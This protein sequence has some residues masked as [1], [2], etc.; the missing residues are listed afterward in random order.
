[1][2][3]TASATLRRMLVIVVSLLIVKVTIA[4]MSGYSNYFPPNF[5]SDFLLGRDDYFFGAYQWVFYPHIVG[6]PVAIFLGLMLVSDRFRQRFPRWHRRL[7]RV[8]VFNV[9]FVVAPSGLGMA[10]ATSTG[11]IAGVGFGGLAVL[12]A[13]CS[14]LGWGAA[15]RRQ[16]AVHR[17]WMWRTFLLLCSAVVLRLLAG[18][19]TVLDIRSPWF[20]PLASW[21]NWLLPLLAFELSRWKRRVQSRSLVPPTSAQPTP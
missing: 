15:V 9:L 21:A 8:Q 4:V 20:D 6:G 19:A 5:E 16:F 17:V 12:T 10:F 3:T 14:A 11:T 7:G 1:M 2:L 18:L 13:F